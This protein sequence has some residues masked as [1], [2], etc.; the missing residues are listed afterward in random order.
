MSV[1]T[2]WAAVVV[3]HLDSLFIQENTE[4]S[5]DHKPGVTSGCPNI[6]TS[7]KREDSG[8]GEGEKEEWE[9]EGRE[10]NEATYE[11]EY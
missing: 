1:W 7:H 8:G 2:L 6:S 11:L 5:E 4:P 9:E 3:S 10:K